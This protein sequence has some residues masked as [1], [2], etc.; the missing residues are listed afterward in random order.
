MAKRKKLSLEER[1]W[2]EDMRGGL[3]IRN[4]NRKEIKILE[5]AIKKI[6]VILK[7]FSSADV[8]TIVHL[9]MCD[10][11]DYKDS[12]LEIYKENQRTE[13]GVRDKIDRIQSEL[14]CRSPFPS[15]GT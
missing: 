15:M 10:R 2:L 3:R 6:R 14:V 4:Y 5:L 13:Q 1:E 11:K 8:A 9:A 12:N 7:D